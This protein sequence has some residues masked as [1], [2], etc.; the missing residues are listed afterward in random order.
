MEP[1][2]WWGALCLEADSAGL[3]F[4]GLPGLDFE[5]EAY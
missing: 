3:Q 1:I 5:L 4:T 2:F